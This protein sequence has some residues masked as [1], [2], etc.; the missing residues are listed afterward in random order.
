MTNRIF[1]FQQPPKD[2]SVGNLCLEDPLLWITVKI[3][4]ISTILFL[5]QITIIIHLGY[6]R[7]FQPRTTGSVINLQAQQKQNYRD[8]FDLRCSL[9]SSWIKRQNQTLRRPL[10]TWEIQGYYWLGCSFFTLYQFWSNIPIP[11]EATK[12]T[13]SKNRPKPGKAPMQY[14]EPYKAKMVLSKRKTSESTSS[15]KMSDET[16]AEG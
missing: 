10:M 5:R 11:R 3:P 12:S 9:V 4:S 13:S 7:F 1:A 8:G 16:L 14:S 15:R 2:F 6:S